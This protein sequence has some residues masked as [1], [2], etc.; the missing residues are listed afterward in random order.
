MSI[1]T[2]IDKAPSAKLEAGETQVIC[3]SRESGGI[4]VTLDYDGRLFWGRVFDKDGRYQVRRSLTRDGAVSDALDAYLD[5]LN[6]EA[7]QR[8]PLDPSIADLMEEVV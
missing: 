6:D 1:A 4:A 5:C 8:R 2:M 7:E 3:D